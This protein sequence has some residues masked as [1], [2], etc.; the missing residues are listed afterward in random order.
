MGRKLRQDV[1]VLMK[2]RSLGHGFEKSALVPHARFL[3]RVAKPNSSKR[4]LAIE[5]S[6]APTGQREFFISQATEHFQDFT[7]GR[8]HPP[9]RVLVFV[10]GE[11][12]F[13]FGLGIVSLTGCGI[14]KPASSAALPSFGSAR[15]LLGGA[16][17]RPFRARA[18][19]FRGRREIFSLL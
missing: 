4:R 15:S 8:E 9:T 7:P 13:E 17:I 6:I 3:G 5:G 12:E 14:N 18:Q 10:H 16:P 1:R 11:H 19:V 2:G